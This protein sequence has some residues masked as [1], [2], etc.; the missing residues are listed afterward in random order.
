MKTISTGRYESPMGELLLA[1]V[2]GK[3][4]SLDYPDFQERFDR[5]LRRRFPKAQLVSADLPEGIR[6]ALDQYFAGSTKAVDELPVEMGGSEFENRVWQALRGI[7]AGETA[8]YGQLAAALDA[9][10]AARAVG[11]ANSM[12]PVAIVVPCH[13]V[14][15]AN[16]TLTGYAGGLERKQWLLDHEKRWA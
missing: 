16:A 2:D 13:R 14:I 7:E 3:L 9:P 12:N 15:G 4:V 1:W 5:L 8:T 10:K 11:R 6:A